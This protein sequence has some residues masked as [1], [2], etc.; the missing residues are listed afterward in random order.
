MLPVAPVVKPSSLQGQQNGK[1]DADLLR[2]VTTPGGTATLVTPANRSW[3]ALEDAARKDG[4]TLGP[5]STYRS[6]ASQE[7]LFTQRYTTEQIATTDRKV[8]NHT[9]YYKKPGVPV[10]AA[11][12]T[13]NHGWG[14]AL[15]LRSNDYPLQYENHP[16]VV[17]LKANAARFGFSAEIQSEKWHW[18]YFAG[19][20]IPA[21]TL[22]YEQGTQEDDMPLTDDDLDRIGA[23][24]QAELKKGT[25]T[26]K[27]DWP[28]TN[29][30]ILSTAQA[31][32]NAVRAAGDPDALADAIT[33]RLVSIS[34]PAGRLTKDD[35]ADAVRS[36]FAEL[37]D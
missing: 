34:T 10:T 12:G 2:S 31:T 19:D 28:S 37:G 11:P 21:A 35:V 23:R 25:G 8:W 20:A 33:Q 9:R 18:R 17:W 32:L 24:V 13:S 36:V 1:V 4:F 30:A 14:L 5:Y 16:A 7:K 6:Y 22:A 29:K 26:G 15:D 3:L 27:P